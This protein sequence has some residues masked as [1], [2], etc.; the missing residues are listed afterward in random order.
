MATLIKGTVSLTDGTKETFAAGPRERIKA[1]RVLKLNP[2]DLQD[3]KAG[4][5]YLAF[6][7]F[8]SL[9]RVGKLEGVSFDAFIDQHLEDYEV[10]ENPE[11]AA[12]P[13]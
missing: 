1:E 4:E 12:P 2:Q 6:L 10:D 8:E 5:E 11:S 3:G 7:I 13:A 9:K